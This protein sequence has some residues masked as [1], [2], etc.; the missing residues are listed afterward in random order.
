MVGANYV[1]SDPFRFDVAASFIRMRG[2]HAVGSFTHRNIVRLGM[3][4]TELASFFWN[5]TS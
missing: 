5:Q 1:A 4:Q 3:L 2:Y